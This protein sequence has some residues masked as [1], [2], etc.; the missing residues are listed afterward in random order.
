MDV[1][2]PKISKAWQVWLSLKFLVQF[3]GPRVVKILHLNYR[4]GIF[5]NGM[6]SSV[7][8]RNPHSFCNFKQTDCELVQVEVSNIRE[9]E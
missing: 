7:E 8:D 9:W 4:V 5:K 2:K 3:N 1:A 6:I